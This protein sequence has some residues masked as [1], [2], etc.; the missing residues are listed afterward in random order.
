[1]D[2]RNF[3][4]GTLQ[5]AALPAMGHV[6]FRSTSL[7][8]TSRR[9]VW[10][11]LLELPVGFSCIEIGRFGSR[12]SDGFRLP[13]KPDGMA[14]FEV[15]GS[16]VLLRNHEVSLG[17]VEEGPLFDGQIPTSEF[18]D[19][20]GMGG[21][22]RTVLNPKTLEIKRTNLALAGTA[23]NCAGG[24]SPWGWLSCE[25]TVQPGHGYVFAVD[26][27]S[28]VLTTPVKIA[29]FGIMNHEAAVADPKTLI[30]YLTEDREDGCLY[31]FLPKSLETPFQ[32]QLQ[33]LK[34]Q[35][36]NGFDTGKEM[37]QGQTLTVEWVS[38]DDPFATNDSLRKQATAKGAALFR[39]GEG[40]WLHGN[41]IYFAAT[42]GGPIGMGQIF[43][44]TTRDA[45]NLSVIAE[46]V[47]R[48]YFKKP[49]NITVAPWG[50]IWAVEDNGEVNCIRLIKSNG[51]LIYFG[52]NVNS[53]GE[54]TGV[55]FSPDGSTMFVNLQEE[56]ITLAVTGPFQTFKG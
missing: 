37:R 6:F 34:I 29:S 20:S 36:R 16:W 54:L 28:D 14:C 53:S 8:A 13:A 3:L 45:G 5:A 1:L 27:R 10:N 44:L 41:S 47:D 40:L 50:D 12:M 49:D 24:I 55:C 39:R 51:D 31:R 18:F 46:S 2:R 11:G 15:D 43:Q 9:Y 38:L 25:E 7:F 42:S 17:A 30:T 23:R 52:K 26:P 19:P 33:A 4:K 56:G 21:V 32:G 48:Y 35:G 22:S